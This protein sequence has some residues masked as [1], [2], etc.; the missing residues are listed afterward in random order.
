MAF[1]DKLSKKIINVGQDVSQS[2]KN[3]ADVVKLNNHISDYEKQIVDLYTIIGKAYYE[4]HKEDLEAEELQHIQAINALRTQIK[5]LQ[6]K[7]KELKGVVKCPQCS[8]DVKKEAQFCSNCGYRMVVA[9]TELHCS[10]CGAV[11]S[12]DIVFCSNCGTRIERD[13][14]TNTVV[15][16]ENVVPKRSCPSC[17][18]IVADDD[19][20]CPECGTKIDA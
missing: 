8:A 12:E 10:N 17:N 7:V 2:T 13:A 3:L 14:T 1:F 18:N 20:F 16:V 19:M 5:D 11:V 15:E 4:N 6:E 9:S